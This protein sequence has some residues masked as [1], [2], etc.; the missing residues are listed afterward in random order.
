MKNAT[1][2]DSSKGCNIIYDNEKP[3]PY[4]FLSPL[5]AQKQCKNILNALVKAD[6]D[7]KDFYERNYSYFIE[8]L[9]AIY[10]NYKEKFSSKSC[11]NFVSN[12]G[13]FEYMCR[14]YGIKMI[15][16]CGDSADSKKLAEEV[17][18]EAKEL[19]DYNNYVSGKSYIEVMNE[20]LSSIYY[21][22]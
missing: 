21:S 2:I 20:N 18:G 22:C 5:E 8:D 9:K 15:F 13:N 4:Y 1:L 10:D 14:D 3:N 19:Y 17:F 6:K 16:Y 12:T 7:N 11:R